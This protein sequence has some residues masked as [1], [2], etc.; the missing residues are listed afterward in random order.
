MMFTRYMPSGSNM[1]RGTVRFQV[2][3]LE[4][5]RSHNGTILNPRK[6]RVGIIQP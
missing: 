1:G 3:A 6:F 2:H 4:L 5:K